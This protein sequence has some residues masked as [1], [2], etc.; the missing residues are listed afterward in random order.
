MGSGRSG[1]AIATEKKLFSELLEFF[2]DFLVVNVD[3][4]MLQ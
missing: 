3:L 4:W 2:C 1:N